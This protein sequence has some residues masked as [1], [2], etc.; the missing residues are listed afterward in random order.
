MKKRYQMPAMTVI[1]PDTEDIL[2]AS[3]INKIESDNSGSG[4]VGTVIW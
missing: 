3:T 4:S 2:T 1:A